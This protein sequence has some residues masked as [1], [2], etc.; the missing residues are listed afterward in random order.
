[1]KLLQKS[2]N[3]FP[4][5]F[6]VFYQLKVEPLFFTD[7]NSYLIPAKELIAGKGN[8]KKGQKILVLRQ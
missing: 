4:G 6:G 7:Q 2:S 8:M 5:A 1:M 3:F